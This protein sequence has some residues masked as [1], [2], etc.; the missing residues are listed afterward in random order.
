MTV[1]LGDRAW[2]W[3]EY[4]DDSLGFRCG[5]SAVRSSYRMRET[6]VR[7]RERRPEG[8]GWQPRLTVPGW[9]PQRAAIRPRRVAGFIPAVW[10]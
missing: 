4:E 5:V 3:T 8:M 9:T 6:S 10:G 2:I 1:R 7:R